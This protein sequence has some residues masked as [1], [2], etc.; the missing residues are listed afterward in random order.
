MRLDGLAQRVS[1]PHVHASVLPARV[2]RVRRASERHA[3]HR[4]QLRH[5]AERAARRR[6]PAPW[7][8][9]LELKFVIP[10]VL[11]TTIFSNFT[12]QQREVFFPK[13]E[14]LPHAYL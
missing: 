11:D 13:W 10:H 6:E 12:L 3:R 4:V 2:A 9:I 8:A 7:W 5:A 14:A 1:G